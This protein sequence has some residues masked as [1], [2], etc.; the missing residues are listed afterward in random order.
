VRPAHWPAVVT[1]TMQ[2]SVAIVV[3]EREWTDLKR[4]G[5]LADD[6]TA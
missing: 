4:Q 5:L 6:G 1:T 2:P 3:D